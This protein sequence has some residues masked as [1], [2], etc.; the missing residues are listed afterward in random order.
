MFRRTQDTLRRKLFFDY[1]AVT[2][3]GST[4]QTIHLKSFFVTP[5]GVSYNPGKQA[6]R[7][8]LFPFRSP[9]LGKSLLLSFPPGTEM[10]Q[11]PGYAPYTLWI[12]VDVLPH[13]GQWVAPFGNPR[14]NVY[15]QLPEAYRC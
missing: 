4:F 3:Y 1:R 8:G 2:F 12:Q 6:Y 10:F 14:I 11:F 5:H 15:L 9:L 7:F 13:Y